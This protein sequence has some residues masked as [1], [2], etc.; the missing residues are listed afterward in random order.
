M[1]RYFEFQ[2]KGQS[3]PEFTLKH[4]TFGVENVYS[5]GS[6]KIKFFSDGQRI[7]AKILEEKMFGIKMMYKIEDIDGDTA[8]IFSDKFHKI[9]NPKNFSV[10]FKNFKIANHII[11]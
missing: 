2:S 5:G 11:D 1:E 7:I 4:I 6:K 3:A 8:T 9:M 10:K